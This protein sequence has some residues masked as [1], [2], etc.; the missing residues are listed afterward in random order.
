MIPTSSNPFGGGGS[1]PGHRNKLGQAFGLEGHDLSTQWSDPEILS[2]GISVFF[3]RIGILDQAVGRRLISDGPLG[4]FLSGGL[5]STVAGALYRERS[6]PL[7]RALWVDY[8]Q[9]AAEPERRAAA[10]VAGTWRV[11]LV[12]TALPLLSEVTRTA[13]VNREAPRNCCRSFHRN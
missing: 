5:D 1:L 9:R 10:A 8:G 4:V 11:P 12:T 7:A 3:C 2:A 6:G 13:L